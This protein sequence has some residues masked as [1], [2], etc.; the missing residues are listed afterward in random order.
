MGYI[1]RDSFPLPTLSL[2][3]KNLAQELY[4]GR[5]FFVLRT[6][7]LDTYSRSEIAILYAGISSHVGSARGK[8]DGT[9]AVLAHIKDLSVSHAHEKGRIGNAAY[10]TAEQ[11]FHTDVG[12]L[13][14]LLAL[15]SAAEGGVSRISSGGRVYNELAATRPDLIKTLSEPWPL[16]R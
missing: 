13:I 3:L 15:Q 2:T 4:S 6:L 14:A 8:Q 7:P 9:G 1:S 16:D 5:G 11:V 10:T 12:D